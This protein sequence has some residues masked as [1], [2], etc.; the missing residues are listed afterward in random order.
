MGDEQPTLVS[1]GDAPDTTPTRA[2]YEQALAATRGAES[3][4]ALRE[5][6]A[7]LYDFAAFMEREDLG[8]ANDLW[9]QCLALHEKRATS[10]ARP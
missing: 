4:S 1:I 10:G 9:R 3:D 6:A 7:I 5:R 2:R 8:Y